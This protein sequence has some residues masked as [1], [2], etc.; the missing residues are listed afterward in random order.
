MDALEQRW[1]DPA[2]LAAAHTWID[3][4]LRELGRSRTGEVSQPHV[5]GW[6]TAMRVPTGDDVVWFKANDEAMV[7]EAAVL[8]LVASRSHGRVP[9]PLAYDPA[10]GWM[11]LADAGTRLRDVIPEERS[12]ER[13]HDVLEACARIQIACEGDVDALL[14][15]GL[16]DRRLPTL[17]GAYA[18]LLAAVDD[19]DPRLPGPDAIEDLCDRLAAFGIRETVQ[20]DDLHD[21]QVFLGTGTHL[22]LDWGDACVSHPL[23]TLAVTL[24]GVIAWGVD[25]EE[26]S[27]DLGPH[28]DAYL[29][30]YEAAYDLAPADLHE[31]A[32]IGTRLGWVC[33]AINGALP[34]D[35]GSTRTRLRMFLDGKP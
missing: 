5:T 29:R 32:R 31:A 22:L 23:F 24:E 12:L 21:G 28:L 30:P 35:P 7:H 17:P 19:T 16:P 1:R 10:S 6:S 15:L 13:W 8:D 18:D 4:R 26:D 34:Q 33:R 25:D 9:A 14:D 20:H 2:F 11:L 27:E 3:A